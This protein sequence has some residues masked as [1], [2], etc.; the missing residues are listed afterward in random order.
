MLM[1]G[2]IVCL[3]QLAVEANDRTILEYN[4]IDAPRP[5]MPA[6]R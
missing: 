6:C 3:G 4:G 2:F 1:F 5:S